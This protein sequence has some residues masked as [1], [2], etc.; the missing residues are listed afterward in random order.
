M[1]VSG[2]AS[3]FDSM[4]EAYADL[5]ARWISE[6]VEMA[7]RPV[8]HRFFEV[9]FALPAF[10]AAIVAASVVLGVNASAALAAMMTVFAS[11][12]VVGGLVS[13]SGNAF[14]GLMLLSTMVGV[15]GVTLFA[16]TGLSALLPL[17]ILVGGETYFIT[18]NRKHSATAVSISIG[19]AL[20]GAGF[21]GFG[22]ANPAIVLAT[23]VISMAHAATI[24]M[25]NFSADIPPQSVAKAS[26]SEKILNA[27]GVV[28]ARMAM[29][30]EIIEVEGDCTTTL[31]ISARVLHGFGLYD[32]I[33]VG[34]RVNYLSALDDIR[35]GM[36]KAEAKVKLQDAS[37][38]G[39]FFT[40][41]VLF[42]RLDD[43]S[44]AVSLMQVEA[45]VS[46]YT[47]HANTLVSE[48]QIH[49]DRYLA[50]VSHELRTPL[51]AILGFSDILQ[52]EMFGALANDR[53][54]EYVALIH[55]SGAHLLSVVN[56][57]LDMSK[58]DM[59]AY[60]IIAEPFEVKDAVALS[61]SMVREQAAAK[62]IALDSK[63]DRA[64]H[65]CT[66]DRRAFQQ[67]VIN[68]LSNAVKFTPQ[69]G[70]VSVT[71]H[72]EDGYLVL[73]VA[74]SGIGICDADLDRI[75]QPFFQVQNDYTRGFEGTGLGLSLVRG[76]VELH[77]GGL[78]IESELGR[79]TSVV[80]RLP[81]AGPERAHRHVPVKLSERRQG[82]AAFAPFFD[83]NAAKGAR[84]EPAIRKTA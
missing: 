84:N 31:G 19:I 48:K 43:V 21:L 5:C 79:G 3:D 22:P 15:S 4:Q 53:Q 26:V 34:D 14:V 42:C 29:T 9:L 70:D 13:R 63:L 40:I 66:G 18:R 52:Q 32:R 7:D 1:L 46:P 82:S 39:A 24:M 49:A 83:D 65:E 77:A 8:H 74:D 64:A 69:G 67:I 58:L 71:T 51:N 54:R 25:R 76:L 12:L 68:L 27:E 37:L 36:S 61:L 33:L 50:S 56:M 45:E 60:Q 10:G 47:A 44:I 2:Q 73:N 59:G 16:L 11:V 23:A 55:Q 28:R 17:A 30:G 38:D 78:S 6:S 57:I 75:G 20:I 41:R 62:N 81:L 80:V 72:A 35:T